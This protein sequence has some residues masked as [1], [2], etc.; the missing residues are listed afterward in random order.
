LKQTCVLYI[1]LN[2]E[3][4]KPVTGYEDLYEISD[5]GNVRNCKTG[6]ILKGSERK[7]GYLCV[8][9]YVNGK[10]KFYLIHRLVALTFLENP[11]NKPS[12]DHIDRNKQNNRLENLKWCT[13]SENQIN[14]GIYSTNT[15]GIK[16]VGFHKAINKYMAYI[17]KNGIQT[18]LGLFN[19]FEEATAVRRQAELEVY[20]KYLEY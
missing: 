3:I 13:N 15:S 16:G 9:F 18:H 19:T 20:G 2:M 6:R 14:T 11:E 17:Y 7:N 1:F 12:V 8:H 10:N 5:F 4:Y